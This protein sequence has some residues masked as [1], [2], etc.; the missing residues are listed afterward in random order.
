MRPNPKTQKKSSTAPAA[1]PVPE[2]HHLDKRA[3]DIPISGSDDDLL[4][5]PETAGLLGVTEKWLAMAR[6]GGY[7][8]PFVKFS[9][10]R[11]RYRR[12][13][14]RMWL[15]ARV[16]QHTKEYTSTRTEL[17]AAREKGSRVNPSL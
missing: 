17:K 11:I 16:H 9:S 14:I 2:R 12:S 4:R 7:G 1:L 3:H 10:R 5:P 15:A 8:P 6:S 13:D